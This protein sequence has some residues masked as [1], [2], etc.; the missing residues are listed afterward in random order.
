MP[1][2]IC[3]ETFMSRQKH[4]QHRRGHADGMSKIAQE[5]VTNRPPQKKKRHKSTG[6]LKKII[7]KPEFSSSVGSR[8]I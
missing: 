2:F 3:L 4:F 1:L 6:D 5:I 8:L 7:Y